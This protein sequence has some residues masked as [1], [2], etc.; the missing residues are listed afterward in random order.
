MEIN[1][2]IIIKNCSQYKNPNT[3]YNDI[4]S[5]ILQK[6]LGDVLVFDPRLQLQLFI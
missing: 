5:V 4:S 2:K 6:P 3:L 1:T